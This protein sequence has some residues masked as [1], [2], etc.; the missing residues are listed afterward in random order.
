MEFTRLRPGGENA[1][2][3]DGR[4][5]PGIIVR[6]IS[7]AMFRWFLTER[8][9]QRWF[10]VRRWLADVW[11]AVNRCRTLVFAK[12]LSPWQPP[13]DLHGRRMEWWDVVNVPCRLLFKKQTKK[14]RAELTSR[15][16]FLILHFQK[17]NCKHGAADEKEL[18]VSVTRS[19]ALGGHWGEGVEQLLGEK[20]RHLEWKC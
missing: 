1:G 3:Y 5:C 4:R 10:R 19:P 15:R 12:P 13:W 8:L 2:L 6:K 16:F 14:T 20:L 11:A 17:Q 7:V 9:M 18:V